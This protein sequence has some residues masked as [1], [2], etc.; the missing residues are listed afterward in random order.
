MSSNS[1]Q[2]SQELHLESKGLRPGAS[3]DR[4]GQLACKL[5]CT[6][7]LS[8]AA[9]P[10]TAASAPVVRKKAVATGSSVAAAGSSAAAS[11]PHTAQTRLRPSAI[12]HPC[13]T[14]ERKH[15]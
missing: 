4:S 1:P 6:R 9:T 11:R 10:S 7:L 13:I 14:I 12:G 2:E 15:M 5:A 8:V 3:V